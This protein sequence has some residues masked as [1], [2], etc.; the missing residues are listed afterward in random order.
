MFG[1]FIDYMTIINGLIIPLGNLGLTRSSMPQIDH[2]KTDEFI[3]YLEANG[4]KVSEESVRISSLRLT[5]NEVNKMKIWKVM[6]AIRNKK[7]I[8]R[9]WVS[10][11]NYV[12]DGSHRFI[13]AYN[14]NPKGRLQVRR[15]DLPVLELLKLS[16]RFNGV[17]YRTISGNRFEQK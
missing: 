14:A 16:R 12:I 11:D 6:K 7:K 8:H 3:A 2:D 4:A 1:G 15:V 13:A 5:Q 10:S 9:V 17:K